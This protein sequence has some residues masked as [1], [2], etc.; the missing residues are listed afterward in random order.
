[1]NMKFE[2]RQPI[3]YEG[4]TVVELCYIPVDSIVGLNVARTEDADVKKIQAFSKLIKNG[5]YEPY[6][7][8]PPVVIK[9][10]EDS[11]ELKNGYHRLRGHIESDQDKMWV[12][13][14]KFDTRTNADRYAS[15]ANMGEDDETTFIKS[16]RT[17]K[18]VIKICTKVMQDE[19]IEPTLDNVIEELKKLKATGRTNFKNGK[20]QKAVLKG[21][22]VKVETITSYP[23]KS[24][25][26]LYR[27]IQ[28]EVATTVFQSTYYNAR[29]AHVR[30]IRN[31]YYRWVETSN[32]ITI[33]ASVNHE[34][35]SNGINK[36]RKQFA[37]KMK[38]EIDFMCAFV[39]DYRS[40]DFKFNPI[41]FIPQSETEVGNKEVLVENV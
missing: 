3:A 37:S 39:D 34:S 29:E 10:D 16:P 41:N 36:V 24:A 32:D 38:K 27:E 20:I 31:S 19:N 13:I 23:E 1:M 30:A 28:P 12:A 7:Y 17:D 15:I 11:Y 33:V 40:G 9:K 22:N 8:E 14:V 35:S 5:G 6:Y 4:M 25:M 26:K 18:D 2:P 21:F